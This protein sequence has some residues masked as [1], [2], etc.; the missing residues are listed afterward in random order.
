[1]IILNY[2]HIAILVFLELELQLNNFVCLP[3]KKSK[4]V[5]LAVNHKCPIQTVSL[6]R[7]LLLRE[8]NIKFIVK[9]LEIVV[10]SLFGSK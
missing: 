7:F 5:C 3:L 4:C 10:L 8:L 6:I 9:L 1:M 2:Q